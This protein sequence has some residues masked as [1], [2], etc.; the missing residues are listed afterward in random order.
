MAETLR[1]LVDEVKS[2][3][4]D[5]YARGE[6]ADV[7]MLASWLDR[8]LISLEKAAPALELM[9]VELA[10]IS[11][12]IEAIQQKRKAAGPAKKAKKK[13]RAKKKG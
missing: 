10:E 11:E 12:V 4:Q 6:A 8:L 7:K 3:R 1:E 5:I 13:S 2:I 9:S